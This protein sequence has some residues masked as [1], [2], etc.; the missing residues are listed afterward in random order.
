[1]R[2]GLIAGSHRPADAFE[3]LGMR[4][5]KL[6]PR[7][8]LR[9]AA[10]PFGFLEHRAGVIRQFNDL[11]DTAVRTQPGASAPPPEMEFARYPG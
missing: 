1:L 7:L 6:C 5:L 2:A 3:L 9:R 8:P 4:R 11:H 10:A